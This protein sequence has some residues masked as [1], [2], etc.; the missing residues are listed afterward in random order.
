MQPKDAL[1]MIDHHAAPAAGV[2]RRWLTTLMKLRKERINRIEAAFSAEESYLER[3]VRNWPLDENETSISQAEAWNWFHPSIVRKHMGTH[4][5]AVAHA[6]PRA[7]GIVDTVMDMFAAGIRRIVLLNLLR[8]HDHYLDVPMAVQRLRRSNPDLMLNYVEF[9]D[10]ETLFDIFA[11]LE[12]Q[13]GVKRT[14]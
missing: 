3:L 8:D 12:G 10:W 6:R 4:H 11:N 2:P 1:I 14:S 7:P 5:M 13:A 9:T